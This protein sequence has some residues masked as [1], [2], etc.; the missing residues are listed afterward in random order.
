METM[1]SLPV[2]QIIL[3]DCR[4]VMRRLPEDSVDCVITLPPYWG[5]RDY[6]EEVIRKKK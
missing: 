1:T 5:L 6:G 4:D 2:N 3:G